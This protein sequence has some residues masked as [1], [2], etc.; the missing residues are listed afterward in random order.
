[1]YASDYKEISALKALADKY[2]ICILLIHH[3]RKQAADDPFQ[4][5]AGSNGLMGASDTSWVMQRK[6]MSQTASILV[7]GRDMDNK[8]LRLHEENCV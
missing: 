1:M 8:T 4:Q 2:N 5:I 7:T 6:R 3:L